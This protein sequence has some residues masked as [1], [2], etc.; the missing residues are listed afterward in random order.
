MSRDK[1]MTTRRRR[2][3]RWTRKRKK[4]RRARLDLNDSFSDDNAVWW[5]LRDKSMSLEF[6]TASGLSE[7]NKTVNERRLSLAPRHRDAVSTLIFIIFL[8]L[9]QATM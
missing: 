3:R 4:R 6:R 2:R 8:F 1:I 7:A 5:R 9:D